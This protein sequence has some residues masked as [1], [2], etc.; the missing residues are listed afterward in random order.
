MPET[1]VG[2]RLHLI[3]YE[4]FTTSTKFLCA[5]E[6]DISVMR[7]G[8]GQKPDTHRHPGIRTGEQ[9]RAAIAQPC[10]ACLIS[11]HGGT[12]DSNGEAWLSQDP[13]ANIFLDVQKVEEVGATGLV[14]LDACKARQILSELAKRTKRGTVL[15]GIDS[16]NTLARDSVHLLADIL[17]ELYYPAK[18]DLSPPAV[19]GAV[20]RVRARITAR[21]DLVS[22]EKDQA[23]GLF[24]VTGCAD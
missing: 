10:A 20:D 15:V 21:N 17:R 3:G 19:M 18:P 4:R 14:I 5:V 2:S 16:E 6:D 1:A 8:W 12:D 7:W 23:P 22:D 24:A 13:K 11:C 9:L